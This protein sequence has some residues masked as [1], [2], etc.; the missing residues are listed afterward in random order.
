MTLL[1]RL[2]LAAIAAALVVEFVAYV[3]LSGFED[4]VL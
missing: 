3:A 1:P 2:A 4:S